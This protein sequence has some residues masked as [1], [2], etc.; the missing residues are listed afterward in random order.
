MRP[1]GRSRVAATSRL[2]AKRT[3][4]AGGNWKKPPVKL[5]A[6]GAAAFFAAL[7]GVIVIFRDH[8]GKEITRV[9]VPQAAS[10]EVK[11]VEPAKDRTESG[12]GKTGKPVNSGAKGTLSK[13]GKPDRDLDQGAV[14]NNHSPAIADGTPLRPQGNAKGAENSGVAN[15]VPGKSGKYEHLFIDTQAK[16]LKAA[17]GGGFSE[18]EQFARDD[19]NRYL[20]FVVH[21][22][23]GSGGYHPTLL[24]FAANQLNDSYKDKIFQLAQQHFYWIYLIEQ[25]G[26]LDDFR[27]ILRKCVAEKSNLSEYYAP[28]LAEMRRSEDVPLLLKATE[29]YPS[30]TEELCKYIPSISDVDLTPTV[31]NAWELVC[32]GPRS[33][34]EKSHLASFAISFGIPGALAHAVDLLEHPE[35][36]NDPVIPRT[37]AVAKIKIELKRRLDASGSVEDLIRWYHENERHLKFDKKQGKFVSTRTPAAEPKTPAA[38]K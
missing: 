3:K 23:R 1:T 9:E 30:M 18:F 36:H 35:L 20:E 13:G 2:N 31:E 15:P 10:A 26:W 6:V 25:K 8:K 17:Q 29:E 38:P 11:L 24:G 27:P 21:F 34:F 16:I 32:G 22:H 14:P 19:I 28:F 37:N 5:I 7:L 4:N 12:D 33:E